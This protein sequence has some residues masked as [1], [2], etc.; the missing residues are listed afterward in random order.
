MPVACIDAFVSFEVARKL[1]RYDQIFRY[2][3]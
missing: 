3:S 2:V 1:Q